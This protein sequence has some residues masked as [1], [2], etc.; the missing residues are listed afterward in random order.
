[1]L[2]NSLA[3]PT[4]CPVGSLQSRNGNEIDKR[5]LTN[6]SKPFTLEQHMM[7][8]GKNW[9]MV[10]VLALAGSF[11]IADGP[12]TESL[13]YDPVSLDRTSP[14][15]VDFGAGT[16]SIYWVPPI[17]A[18]GFDVAGPGPELHVD[19]LPLGLGSSDHIDAMSNGEAA[20][21]AVGS[22]Q[23]IY[24]S[25]DAASTGQAGTQVNHQ[26][27]RAQHA[28]DRFMTTASASPDAAYGGATATGNGNVLSFN[29]TRY[30]L[31]PTIPG[32]TIAEKINGYNT[33]VSPNGATAM[34][35]AGAMEVTD[36]DTTGNNAQDTAVY[37]SL[38]TASPTLTSIGASKADV[39]VATAYAG[40][41]VAPSI[42]ADASMLGLTDNDELDAIAVWNYGTSAAEAGTDWA[43]FSLA[44]GSESLGGTYSAADIFVTNFSGDSKLYLTAND[45]GLEVTDDVDALDVLASAIAPEAIPEPGTLALLSLAGLG[46]VS[47]RR[48]SC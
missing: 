38:D 6:Q 13:R 47:R 4:H 17:E 28:A 8:W 37:M 25:V 11:A 32:T 48:R 14:S 46:L 19:Y 39:I 2:H 34:D 40:T 42:F 44:P 31:I 29:H 23:F 3:E 18:G 1:M 24:F 16:S 36:I 20:E 10:A 26:Y 41:P 12:G 30:Q 27:V 15:V 33:Y 22:T 9:M 43:I 35:D 45:L 7:N 5:R 21:I